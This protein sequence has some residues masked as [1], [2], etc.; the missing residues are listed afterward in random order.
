MPVYEYKCSSCGKTHEVIQKHSD[1]PVS[2]CPYC[3]GKVKK[4]IS[5]TSFVLKGTGWYK[6]DYASSDSGKTMNAAKN[7]VKEEAGIKS[8]PKGE[9]TSESKD[10]KKSEAKSEAKTETASNS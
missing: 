10:N 5:N 3:G 1:K 4:L 7:A 2:V 8:E 6:T 9:S